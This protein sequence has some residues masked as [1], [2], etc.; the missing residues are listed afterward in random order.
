M[1]DIVKRAENYAEGKVNEVLTQ[2]ITKAY[3][4][5][6]QDGYRDCE[7]KHSVDI[8]NEEGVEDDDVEYVDLELPSGTLWAK[9][10]KTD[11]N[12]TRIYM[13]HS[14][15]NSL[16]IPTKEQWDELNRVCR[17]EKERYQSGSLKKLKI[18]GPNGRI[19]IFNVTGR[20]F[21]DSIEDTLECYMWLKDESN[22]SSDKNAVR[23]NEYSK[24]E[25]GNISHYFSGYK[26]PVRLVKQPK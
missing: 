15:A 22:E 5:G 13:P 11:D 23:F 24:R 17:F 7:A 3:L 8:L 21:T 12:N 25:E 4:E 9:D 20:F 6:Y 26:L 16:S 19:L 14:E 18:V 1:E 2:V 10:Y